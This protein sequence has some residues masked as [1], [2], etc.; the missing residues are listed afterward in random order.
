MRT[1]A[2]ALAALLATA[3]AA[4]A[5]DTVSIPRV[6]SDIVVDGVLDDGAW[7]S[8]ASF[9]V[10]YET[11]PGDNLPARVRT[12]VRMAHTDDALLL[13]FDARDPDP[14][15]IRAFLRDRDALYRDDFVGVMLDTF[16]DQRRAYEF[17]VNPL[18][19]QA[20]L[21]RDEATGNEDDSWDGLWTSAGRITADGYQVEMRI[22]FATLRFRDTA[23]PRRWGAS[24]LRIRPRDFRYSYFSHRVERGARCFQCAF[25]A[26]EGFQGVRQGL[27]L[28]VTPTLTVAASEQRRRA[29]EAWT[30]GDTAVEP[31]LD[32]AW[33]P[34]PNLTLNATI[35]P[36]FSQVESDQ[37]QLDLNTSFALFFPEK[38]PFFLEG[39]DYFNTP[40]QV[41]YTRQI[42]DP[43]AGLRLT[44]RSGVH[45]YGVIAARDA[46]TQLLLPGTLG[47]SIRVLDQDADAFV[48][49]YRANLGDSTTL[50]AIS[51][52]RHG[53]DYRNALA[54]VDARWQRGIHTLRAQWLASDSRYPSALGL[55]DAAPRGDALFAHYSAG[56]RNWSANLQHRRIDPGFRA[57]L[58]FVSQVGVETSLV[59]GSYTWF[60]DGGTV[61]RLGV[62]GDFDIT[63]DHTGRLLERE[64]EGYV[65]LNAAR[66][67][68]ANMGG[69]ARDRY[70]NGRLF[71]ERFATAY[72]ETQLLPALKVGSWQRVGDMLDLAASRMGRG[73]VWQPW[74]QLDVG[75]GINLA[76]NHTRQRLRRGGGTAFDAAVFDARLSWQFDPRQRLRLSLQASDVERDPALY[77]FP[78]AECPFTPADPTATTCVVPVSA[79]SRDVAAQLLYSYKVDPR[80]ALYAGYSHG[81]FDIDLDG[82]LQRDSLTDSDRGLFVKLSYA[83]QPRG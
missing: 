59:G 48:A 23:G 31:G 29:G 26:I 17:F 30:R 82:D 64:I 68:S 47:S 13:A 8:A 69:V 55:A 4:S 34:S 28:E 1:P 70:W 65:S 71:D 12:T 45:A 16:D 74:L 49:R 24:F 39:A 66:Q 46:T 72:L 53:E 75:R 83:W 51:T 43:D 50:G 6:G 36:D 52:F 37:A 5:A 15:A 25:H 19:V 54:G 10:A 76:L 73:L 42:A 2:L 9:D 18:G 61:S 80:T 78:R 35:N 79:S 20:D 67:T 60:R 57:D 41:L 40:L 77:R 11:Q 3:T 63:Y 33:A 22:P 7:S 27:N 32:V 56:K 21:I 14:S 81:A 44:G 58:G 38:R 62:N